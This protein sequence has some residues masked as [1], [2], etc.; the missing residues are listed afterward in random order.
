MNI[1]YR[2]IGQH[3][4]QMRKTKKMTQEVLA[5]RLDVSVGYVSQIERG[6]TKISLDLLAA[7]ATILDCEIAWLLDG[8][9]VGQRT[10]LEDALQTKIH[11]LSPQKKK[12]LFQ[13]AE[14]LSQSEDMT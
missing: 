1:D 5:E 10:Y 4:K 7:I 3:I 14:V 9:S 8:V 6:A 2:Q 11:T 13:I 12:L